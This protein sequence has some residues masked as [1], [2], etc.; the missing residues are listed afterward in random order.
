MIK[1]IHI[2][3]ALALLINVQLH[4]QSPYQN[5][6]IAKQMSA[7]EYPPCEPSICIDPTN[8]ANMVAGIVLDRV[9]TSSDSGKTW[10]SNT[11]TSRLG[12]YGDPAII[13]NNKGDFYYFHLGDPGGQGWSGDRLLECIVSQRSTNKGITWSEGSAIGSNAPKDQDKQWAICSPNSKQVYATWT[14]F[15]KYESTVPTDSSNI[16]FSRTNRKAKKWKKAMRINEV[17]GTCADDDYTVEGA[18][19]AVGPDGE[20]YVAWAVNDK[21]YFDRSFNG[22]KTWL[23]HD[24]TAAT[25][26]GGWNQD[27]PGIMRAN[28]MPVLVCDNSDGP[29]RGALYI[30]WSDT[31]NGTDDVDVWMTSSLDKGSSWSSPVRVNDDAKGKH[32]FFPWLTIDQA[33]GNLYVVF[34][35][36]RNY[37]DTTT[38][39]YLASSTDGGKMWLNERISDS[40]F[41]PTPDVFFGDY[42]NIS[43]VNGVVR[44]IWTRL[45]N[46]QLSVWTAIIQK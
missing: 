25:I 10:V 38:D 41:A 18:V 37:D 35:D 21:I 11:L 4:S 15:D 3:C 13:A 46:G 5:V 14:Q 17:A 42:N 19:P 39:V 29:N 16:L 1:S 43:V 33:T 24:I 31:K 26:H 20:V 34:Y 40:P 28:G 7:F 2:L 9:C 36:R 27:I 30:C 6:V 12:V 8:P 23:Q 32:Q 22:G 44:P 45:H